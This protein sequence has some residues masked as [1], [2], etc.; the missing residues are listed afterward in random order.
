MFGLFSRPK[1]VSAQVNDT[2]I[3][4]EPKE[5]LLQAALR[6][7]IAFPHSCR[8]GGCA[9]CKCQLVHGRVRQL[10]DA[11]YILSDDELDRGFIL[12]CQSVP[13]T[14]VSI[15]VDLERGRACRQVPGKVI[16]HV[17]LTHDI[18]HLRIQLDESLSYRAGQYA[19]LSLDSLPG[20]SR[21]YSFASQAQADATVNFFVR[22]VPEGAFTS[23][24]QGRSLVGQGVVVEGP[25]GDFF[26]RPAPAPL[27]LMAGGSGLAP[28][29]AL[30]EEAL[31]EGVRRPVVLLFGARTQADLYALDVIDRLRGQWP[32][33]FAFL[34]ILSAEPAGSAWG[35]LRG[36]VADLI[37]THAPPGCHAYLCGPPA[38]VD[39]AAAQLLKQGVDPAH[40]HADRFTTQGDVAAAA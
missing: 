22:W 6:Q 4:V 26:L 20:V 32:E 33:A 34:P 11:G 25:H 36:L 31:D 9:A 3:T 14:D 29:L 2:V 37:P 15:Q 35:G 1:A 13:R 30:L 38:M 16:R 8:V 39:A 28:L 18:S 21:S 19:Q 27:L 7:G 17:Q 23:R 24:V 10:T 40:V 5:T 12:A